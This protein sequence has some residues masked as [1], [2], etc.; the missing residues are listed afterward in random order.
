VHFFTFGF[1]KLESILDLLQKKNEG[2]KQHGKV[3]S[4]HCIELSIRCM[5]DLALVIGEKGAS[6]PAQK[7][8]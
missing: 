2:K 4:F 7:K 5:R 6:L 1:R 3:N 8:K